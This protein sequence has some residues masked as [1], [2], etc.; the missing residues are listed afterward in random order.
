MDFLAVIFNQKSNLPDN[1]TFRIS[2][3][4]NEFRNTLLEAFRTVALFGDAYNFREVHFDKVASNWDKVSASIFFCFI[5]GLFLMINTENSCE[6]RTA[7]NQTT[8]YKL[9]ATSYKL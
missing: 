4:G 7:N 3:T 5:S 9:R 8:G 2:L 6:L 1:F